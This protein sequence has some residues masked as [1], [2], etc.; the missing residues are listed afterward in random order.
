MYRRDWRPQRLLK[1]N[2]QLFSITYESIC[3]G[4]HVLLKSNAQFILRVLSRYRV[5][6]KEL[7]RYLSIRIDYV[8]KH[9]NTPHDI[10]SIGSSLYSEAPI[11]EFPSVS[12]IKKL[13]FP[14]FLRLSRTSSN[15][16]IRATKAMAREDEISTRL[17]LGSTIVHV[18]HDEHCTVSLRSRDW[19][20]C[21]KLRPWRKVSIMSNATPGTSSGTLFEGHSKE[22]NQLL[23]KGFDNTSNFSKSCHCTHMWPES[24]TFRNFKLSN[25]LI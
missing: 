12:L 11:S 23:G 13:V 2:C 1:T 16:A 9:P 7:Q 20:L 14:V 6:A 8:L 24:R 21:L 3:Y 25:S 10:G 22:D 4:S 5:R 15:I 17:S 19:A 18:S